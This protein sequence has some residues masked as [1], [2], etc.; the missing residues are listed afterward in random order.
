MQGRGM[1]LSQVVIHKLQ[2]GNDAEIELGNLALQRAQMPEI[3]Q[4]ATMMVQDHQAL[5]EKLLPM[6]SGN[7][8]ASDNPLSTEATTNRNAEAQVRDPALRDR[9]NRDQAKRDQTNRDLANRDPN[10]Q[11]AITTTDAGANRDRGQAGRMDRNAMVP[12]QLVK[13]MDQACD[14]SLQMTKEMLQQYQ[15]QDF[16]MAYLG[17]Q[18][19]AHTTTLAELQAIE[20]QGPQELKSIAQEAATKVKGHLEQ[21]KQLANKLEDD[22]RTTRAAQR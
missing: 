5:N 19:V 18:I 4:F 9:P 22:R 17:Q 14:N 2:K 15:G 10:Q 7:R 12:M 11:G 21:A 13:V 8:G 16:A 3:Q 20:S 1:P 6:L